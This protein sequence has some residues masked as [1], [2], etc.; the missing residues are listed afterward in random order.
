MSEA[1]ISITKDGRKGRKKPWLVRWYSAYDPTT[2]TK[3]RYSKSFVRRRQAERFAEDL[4]E[5]LEA[6]ITPH[7]KNI[8]LGEFCERYLRVKKNEYRYGTHQNYVQTITRLTS[9]FHPNSL[10]S[11]ITK[12]YAE[13]FVAEITFIDGTG[14]R[15]GKKVAD[16]TRN[17]QLRNCKTMFSKAVEWGYLR[18][19][20]FAHI[21]QVKPQKKRWHYISPSEFQSILNVCT[22]PYKRAYYAV[23]YGCGLRAG[24]AVNLL[25]DGANIDFASSQITIMNRL[26]TPDIPPY[27]IKDYET[28][29]VPMPDWVVKELLD[30]YRNVSE[31]NPFVFLSDRKWNTIH[32]WWTRAQEDGRLWNSNNMLIDS[33]RDFKVWCRRAGVKSQDRLCQHSMRKSW[34][35][36]L[37]NAGV[38]IQTLMKLGGWSSIECCQQYYLQSTDENEKRAV[39]V[40]NDL[41]ADRETSQAQECL[42]R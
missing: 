34:A 12:E 2:D 26:A 19:N 28:R 35:T 16:S 31:N 6:G 18:T 37:A 39:R 40:L 23:Q 22:D 33:D 5:D 11:A 3:K 41:F 10:L 1:N 15:R 36:N 9:H 42:Q 32:R 8:T 38:P 24:E 13:Q 21:K 7:M 25:W 27:T 17:L 29:S 20:P 4:R 30:L 14:K